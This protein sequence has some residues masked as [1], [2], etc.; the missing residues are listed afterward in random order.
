MQAE[1]DLKAVIQSLER[2]EVV[3]AKNQ[4]RVFEIGLVMA[5][6]V[7]AGAYTAGVIDFLLEALE[8]YAKAGHKEHKHNVKLKVMSGASAGGMQ[9]TITAVTLHQKK[10]G[11]YTDSLGRDAWINQVHIDALLEEN[12]LNAHFE[13]RSLLDSSIIEKIS[14]DYITDQVNDSDSWEEDLSYIDKS[15]KIFLTLTNLRGLPYEFELDGNAG[16]KF[17]MREHADYLYKEITG[18]TSSEEWEELRESTVATGAFPLGLSA[19]MISRKIDYYQD[20]RNNDNRSISPFFKTMDNNED[21]YK[22]IA[23]DGGVLNNEPLELARKAL[24]KD[25]DNPEN[26]IEELLEKG[27]ILLEKLRMEESNSYAS[28]RDRLLESYAAKSINKAII[29]IDPFPNTLKTKVNPKPGALAL[30]KLPTRIIGAIRGQAM[31]KPEELVFTGHKD[32][33]NRFAIAPVRY[34]DK[35]GKITE[36]AIACGFFEGFGG[37]F[38]KAFRQHDYELGKRNCQNFLSKYF[39]LPQKYFSQ[40][41]AFANNQASIGE[42]EASYF[43]IIPLYGTSEDEI[44]QPDWPALSSASWKNTKKL[45]TRRIHAVLGRSFKPLSIKSWI[46]YLLLIAVVGLLALSICGDCY[47]LT[48]IVCP[49]ESSWTCTLIDLIN[50]FVGNLILYLLLFILLGLKFLPKLVLNW[51]SKKAIKMIE[52]EMEDYGIS[53]R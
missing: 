43:P 46:F 13:V 23:V 29:L 38:E 53:R 16:F 49:D 20:R 45:L 44:P 11:T 34:D 9:T 30:W 52:S 22:F 51:I 32:N 47:D 4:E 50:S 17:G 48:E 41:V 28:L 18:E 14:R 26:Q 33:F 2:L 27:L 15:F 35:G 19:R 7:S 39:V 25:E 42:E 8:N 36:N 10:S 40:N 21:M 12:D 6:A 1:K 24:Y 31:F 3:K 5:G 37:F